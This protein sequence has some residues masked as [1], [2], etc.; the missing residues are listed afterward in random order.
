MLAPLSNRILFLGLTLFC[1]GLIATGYAFQY[2]LHLEPC[3]LCITQRFFI[4]LAGV[5]ALLAALHNPA[6][7]GTAVYSVFIVLASTAGGIFSSRQLYLQSLPAEQ[8]PA[9][10][11]SIAYILDTFPV[12]K[13]LEILLKG[14]GNCAEVVWS[15]FGVSIPGWTLIAF[16]MM[17]ATCIYLI[18]R[19]YRTGCH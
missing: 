8:A 15:L 12:G 16:A 14:D 4:V 1:C 10:G 11:P 3:P 19:S 18:S 6:R 7:I 13:A 5:L 17:G 2:G 9:C